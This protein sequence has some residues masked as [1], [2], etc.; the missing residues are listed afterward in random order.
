MFKKLR[1]KIEMAASLDEMP[2]GFY[3]VTAWDAVVKKEKKKEGRKAFF[4]IVLATFI[5]TLAIYRGNGIMRNVATLRAL[6]GGDFR[7]WS[8]KYLFL[9]NPPSWMQP[10]GLSEAIWANGRAWLLFLIDFSWWLSWIIMLAITI[11]LVIFV[12]HLMRSKSFEGASK[13]YK[14]LRYIEKSL[15]RNTSKIQQFF[16]ALKHEIF[17]SSTL[18]LV[19]LIWGINSGYLLRFIYDFLITYCSYFYYLLGDEFLNVFIWSQLKAIWITGFNILFNA[20]IWDLIKW[21]L[22]IYTIIAF[23]MAYVTFDRNTKKLEDF[24]EDNAGVG[25]PL[26]GPSGSGKTFAMNSLASAN[27]RLARKTIR[28]FIDETR[29]DYSQEINFYNLQEFFDNVKDL[30]A[31]QVMAIELADDFI[32]LE[33][34]HR[35]KAPDRF[36]GSSPNLEDIIHWY[37]IGLYFLSKKSRVL[38]NFPA[39]ITDDAVGE[40]I[41]DRVYDYLTRRRKEIPALVLNLNCFKVRS[42]SRMDDTKSQE[43]KEDLLEDFEPAFIF[44]AG[45]TIVVTEADKD[46]FHAFKSQLVA[47]K[48]GD[49]MAVIRHYLSFN[50]RSCGRIFYDAQADDGVAM[51]IRDRFDTVF[52]IESKFKISHSHWLM[53]FT[54]LFEIY[55]KLVSF[56]M[57]EK[58]ETTP[59]KRTAITFFMNKINSKL[60]IFYKYLCSFDYVKVQARRYN[61]KGEVTS[62]LKNKFT[63]K[64]NAADGFNTYKSVTYADSYVENMRNPNIKKVLVNDLPSWADFDYKLNA[65][66]AQYLHS[67]FVDSVIYPKDLTSKVSDSPSG[68]YWENKED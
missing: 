53:P 47:M 17:K 60:R 38:T 48:T 41:R 16:H 19:F 32:T 42:K 67:E 29:L 33:G 54:W 10:G 31:N 1:Q 35:K 27:Q 65:E 37:F 20:S 8:I 59:Y 43:R 55:F 34:I 9:P 52:G 28:K 7:L 5:V 57:K 4:L 61:A 14:L 46:W 21:S 13:R 25:V 49:I 30:I 66:S 62:S 18:F 6:F 23:I 22:L 68:L 39:M 26:K 15:A 51:I 44:E 63:F 64:I 3:K 45:L 58:Q 36:Y 40:K 2:I 50:S 12:F 11:A 24:I 56:F